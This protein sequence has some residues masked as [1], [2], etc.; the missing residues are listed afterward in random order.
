MG[1]GTLT[2]DKRMFDWSIGRAEEADAPFISAIEAECFSLP[3]TTEQVLT[4]I[5]DEMYLILCSRNSTNNVLGYAGMYHVLDEGYI[6]NVA[7]LPSERRKHIA[8]ELLDELE[9]RARELNLS[10]LTLEVRE[11]NSPAAALY[12]KHGFSESGLRKD[13]YQSPRENALIMTK[14]LSEEKT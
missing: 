2:E 9:S 7:V 3:L 5:R 4:Q 8:D 13:Y 14:F 1:T 6:T 11:S 10:F 12:K